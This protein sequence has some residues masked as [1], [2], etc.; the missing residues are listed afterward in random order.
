MG[1]F[2]V[3]RPCRYSLNP[4]PLYLETEFS[5]YELR[6][7]STK[8]RTIHQYFYR[9]HRIAQIAISTAVTEPA[10][11]MSEFSAAHIGAWDQLTGE[12]LYDQNFRD[13][14]CV[15]HSKLVTC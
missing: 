15:Y 13:A 11:G 14:V 2:F 3:E 4:S 5:W 7:P 1:D 8:Y 6:V 9:P 12:V 10:M